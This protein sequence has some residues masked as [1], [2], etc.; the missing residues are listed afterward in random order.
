MLGRQGEAKQG[1]SAAA[2][3]HLTSGVS[4]ITFHVSDRLPAYLYLLS[5]LMFAIVN[6]AHG[7]TIAG[8][9]GVFVLL[10]V[11]SA[12]RGLLYAETSADAEISETRRHGDKAV[13]R[14]E[15]SRVFVSTFLVT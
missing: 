10:V 2:E 3:R 5:T 13:E 12:Q 9:V 1:R 7:Y 8:L 6:L 15:F 11:F 4:R 14:I